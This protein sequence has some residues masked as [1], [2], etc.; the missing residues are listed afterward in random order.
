MLEYNLESH[1]NELCIK[2]PRYTS[3]NSTWTLNKRACSD[4]LKSVLMRYPHYSLHDASHSEAVLS[5]MEMLLGDRIQKLSPTDTWLLL[6]AAYVHDLGMVIQ[7]D[8][9]EK[10]WK[11][12]DFRNYLNNLK[13]SSD[14]EIREA[15]DFILNVKTKDVVWPLKAS[16]YVSL[17]NADYFRSKH[18]QRCK[19]LLFSEGSELQVDLGH[20]H[21]VQSRL[22]KLLGEICALHTA[23]AEKIL[24]LDYQTNGFDSDYAHPRFVAMLLR[25]GDLLDIDNNRFNRGV[26]LG[27]GHLPPT[28]I[29]HKEKHNATAHLLVTPTEISFRSSCPNSESYLEAQRFVGW[30]ESEVSFLTIHWAKIV[31]KD[32]GGYAPCF[33]KKELQINGVESIPGTA[34]L[35]F[36]ISQNKAFEVIEGS[37]L[38][39]DRFVFIREVLQN[40]MDASK[41]QLWRDLQAGTYKAWV[42]SELDKLQPYDLTNEIYSNYPITVNLS[43]LDDGRVQV[44][45]M[46]RGTGISVESFKEM[47][48][49]AVSNSN[50]QKAQKEIQSMP[51]WLQPTAGFGIGL[52]SIFLVADQFEI[53]TNTGTESLHAVFHSRRTGGHVQLQL[54]DKKFERGT[55]ITVQFKQPENFSFSAVGIT[56]QYLDT[57][58]DLLSGMSHTGEVRV[59]EA[60]HAHCQDSQFPITVSCEE[61][62]IETHII[63]NETQEIN[64]DRGKWGEQYRYTI[65]AN[66]KKTTIWDTQ[67]FAYAEFQFLKERYTINKI[68][69]KGM[70]IGRNVPRLGADGISFYMDLYGLNTKETITLDR[71]SFTQKGAQIVNDQIEKFKNVF[72]AIMLEFIEK[73]TNGIAEGDELGVEPYVFWRMCNDEQR[74]RIPGDIVN[75]IHDEI[76]VISKENEGFKEKPI[77]VRDIITAL[78][79]FM[80]LKSLRFR[81]DFRSY[82]IDHKRICSIL[83]EC[84]ENLEEKKIIVSD[85]I[86]NAIRHY[87]IKQLKIVGKGNRIVLYKL[88][89]TEV[90]TITVDSKDEKMELLK[91]LCNDIP[92]MNYGGVSFG[93]KKAKR[94]AIPAISDYKYLAVRNVPYGIRGPYDFR[95]NYIISPF[96]R[97]ENQNLSSMGKERFVSSIIETKHFKKLVEYVKENSYRKDTSIEK[98][99]EEYVKL[100]HDYYDATS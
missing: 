60:I 34:G 57:E 3:L 46:D 81:R 28:S 45:V 37:N 11:E 91:G 68:L 92:G 20:N 42:K 88:S 44:K 5:K 50:S 39:E 59:V 90:E 76:V 47:C 13:N 87:W 65:H 64:A 30:L 43:T 27:F 73:D 75:K 21:L 22:I 31:P 74:R 86:E 95:C 41:I 78:E 77:K 25:L 17:I 1:L 55:L 97:D 58:L 94:Y 61:S 82:D 36:Q 2:Y 63:G 89:A 14:S 16:R 38:Y 15:A 71:R 53:D 4:L 67:D 32:L 18:A 33:E 51:K 23:P 19:S 29:P 66:E 12:A 93:G 83:N 10:L 70:E 40:A 49:V 62:T 9:I 6:H 52:Q 35:K 48:N 72:I 84:A 69:F 54:S 80:Y 100:L 8:E 98:I 26:E 96:V 85:S 7:W 24:E 79:N 56:G 99:K